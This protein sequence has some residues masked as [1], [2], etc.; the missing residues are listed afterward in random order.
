M[1][2]VL[3]SVRE[4]QEFASV[5]D[6]SQ[7]TEG[8]VRPPGLGPSIW[9]S[10][11]NHVTGPPVDEEMEDCIQVL[12]KRMEMEPGFGADE[13]E[14][15]TKKNQQVLHQFLRARNSHMDKSQKML[16]NALK[17]RRQRLAGWGLL[18]KSRIVQNAEDLKTEAETGKVYHPGLDKWGRPILVF[19]NHVE[20]TWKQ[21]QNMKFLCW[22][23]ERAIRLMPQG[24]EKFTIFIRLEDFSLFNCPPM[25][26]CPATPQCLRLPAMPA[27]PRETSRTQWVRMLGTLPDAVAHLKQ[28]AHVTLLHRR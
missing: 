5:E 15:C 19:D 25:K 22:N 27:A 18:N 16:V 2:N 24:V 21:D 26:V 20:N 12:K 11:E 28:V 9:Q 10:R 23:M 8:Q 3:S 17:W 7:D 4:C 14:F 13:A 1:A 6:D